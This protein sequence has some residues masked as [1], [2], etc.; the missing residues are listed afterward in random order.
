MTKVIRISELT[1]QKVN[2]LSKSYKTSKKSII[3][4]A[5]ERLA[6]EDL[7]N[8]ANEAYALLKSDPKLWQEELAE[9]TLW[10]CTLA[11]GLKDH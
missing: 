2:Q 4:K 5:V 11:D 10:E 8:R 9:R 7:L 6:R 3:E 1:Y